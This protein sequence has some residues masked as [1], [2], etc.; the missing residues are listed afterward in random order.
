MAAIPT[1]L[2]DFEGRWDV[3][4]EIADARGADGRFAGEASFTREGAGLAYVERGILRLGAAEMQAERRYVW[5]AGQGVE[6]W[7]SDGRF[8][9]PL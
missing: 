5:S 3:S 1:E 9:P 4:R 6:V 7:F 8:F 2:W